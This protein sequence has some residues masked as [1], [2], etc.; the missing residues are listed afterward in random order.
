MKLPKNILENGDGIQNSYVPFK[1]NKSSTKGN[2]DRK[3]MWR[4]LEAQIYYA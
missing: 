2:H 4:R 1:T 3:D